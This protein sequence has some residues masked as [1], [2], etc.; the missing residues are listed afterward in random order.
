MN[1]RSRPAIT[2]RRL[3]LKLPKLEDVDVHDSPRDRAVFK[4]CGGAADLSSSSGSLSTTLD[5]SS[6]AELQLNRSL[7]AL[8]TG[9]D[10]PG[11]MPP[12][13]S[14][15]LKRR[16]VE[17][18]ATALPNF[19]SGSVEGLP[20]SKR[21]KFIPKIQVVASAPPA[22]SDPPVERS[23]ELDLPAEDPSSLQEQ[24]PSG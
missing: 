11:S 6:F 21:R 22:I 2:R 1:L 4:P 7:E 12:H 8:N 23:P 19:G 5:G 16:G 18:F 24:S 20:P 15:A 9:E 3:V 13:D 17:G 10:E 14:D